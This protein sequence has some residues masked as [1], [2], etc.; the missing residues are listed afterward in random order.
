MRNSAKLFEAI[1]IYYL[2]FFVQ[3]CLYVEIR[4]LQKKNYDLMMGVYT[5]N[6]SLERR[7]RERNCTYERSCVK[8]ETKYVI[9]SS[10]IS[11]HGATVLAKLFTATL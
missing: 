5:R 10:Y 8:T 2:P 7:M 1:F 11:H 9:I 6:M 4:G 3:L